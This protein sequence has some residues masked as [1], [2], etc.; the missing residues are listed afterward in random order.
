VLALSGE[1]GFEPKIG[2]VEAGAE[3]AAGNTG[4]GLDIHRGFLRP[5]YS[6]LGRP[7]AHQFSLALTAW[8]Q[9]AE[10]V[11]ASEPGVAPVPV[12]AFVQRWED[13][14]AALGVRPDSVRGWGLDGPTLWKILTIP[15]ETASP[16]FAAL[17]TSL[18]SHH[19]RFE[20][21]V[22]TASQMSTSNL[23][24]AEVAAGVARDL[25]V[26]AR[27][28]PELRPT[29][30]DEAVAIEK[31]ASKTAGRKLLHA[32]RTTEHGSCGLCGS[33]CAPHFTECDSCHA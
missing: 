27:I 21:V 2:L 32:L 1:T 3:A 18:A 24:E 9:L 6:D 30:Y 10:T 7:E 23:D 4:D 29:L 20:T 14:A 28:F 11:F 8:F 33:P 16:A 15:V 12:T 13:A 5:S 17:V 19:D 25:M 22:Q 31:T 26:T